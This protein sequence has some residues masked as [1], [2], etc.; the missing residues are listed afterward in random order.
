MVKTMITLHRLLSFLARFP[1]RCAFQGSGLRKSLIGRGSSGIYTAYV[2]GRYPTS[3]VRNITFA[4][5]RRRE[6]L[7]FSHPCLSWCQTN[8][9]ML[10]VWPATRGLMTLPVCVVSRLRG[11]GLVR[12]ERVSRGGLPSRGR[13]KRRLPR[14]KTDG[15][16][17]GNIDTFHFTQ[18]LAIAVLNGLALLRLSL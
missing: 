9:L 5:T 15:P 2:T 6:L 7:T 13:G 4:R 1:N 16:A 18:I 10:G 14:T 8:A 11:L 3:S 17:W 12:K